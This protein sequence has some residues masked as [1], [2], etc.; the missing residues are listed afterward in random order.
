MRPPK[1]APQMATG[2]LDL[3]PAIELDARDAL[4]WGQSLKAVHGTFRRA[5]AT[6]D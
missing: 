4:L 6:E 3:K 2:R 1:L 5:C